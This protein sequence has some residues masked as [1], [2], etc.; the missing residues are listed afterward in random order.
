ML[1]PAGLIGVTFSSNL[2]ELYIFI[3]LVL[4]PAFLM[5]NLFGYD[6]RYR[7]AMMYLIW[8]HLGAALFLVGSV[9]AFA[10]SGSFEVSALSKVSGTSIAFWVGF[11]ISIGWLIKMAV[12]GFHVWIRYAHGHTPTSIAPIIAAIVGLGNYV[13]VRLLIQHLPYVFRIFSFPLMIWALMTMIYGAFLTISQEDIKLLYACS[14]INQTSYSLLGISSLT[15][16]GISGGI[17]YFLSHS[18]G[19]CILFLVAGTILTQ[20]GLRDMNKM[21]GLAHRMPFTATLCILGSMILSAIPPL[22][23][24]QA[25][26]IMFTGIFQSKLLNSGS[27]SCCLFRNILFSSLYFL[28]YY[29]HIFWAFTTILRKSE[30]STIIYDRS[31]FHPSFH[32]L[33]HRHLSKHNNAFLTIIFI[34]RPSALTLSFFHIYLENIMSL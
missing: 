3:E 33:D 11:F 21:G 10:N 13:I 29:A 20:T 15:T 1:F 5:I 19:K 32:I 24:F 7:I 23:G 25:E 9:L 27:D 30:R 18:L 31:A 14:T 22:S 28:A 6:N 4:V 16:F 12:F 17:F 8:N 34:G 26:W 2:I